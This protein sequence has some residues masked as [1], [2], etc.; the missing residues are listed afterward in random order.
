MLKRHQLLV[1]KEYDDEVWLTVADS[2]DNGVFQET[3]LKLTLLY[4]DHTSPNT[5]TY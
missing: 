4:I 1:K 5:Y 2:K 3:P